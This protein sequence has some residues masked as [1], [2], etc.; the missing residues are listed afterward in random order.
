MHQPTRVSFSSFP[1]SS[2]AS[3]PYLST[4]LF[5]LMMASLLAATSTAADRP[6]IPELLPLETVAC[7]RVADS[8]NLVERFQETALGRM[9]KDPQI[10]PLLTQLFGSATDAF[11]QIEERLGLSLD[12]LLKL[13][14]GEIAL[15]VVPMEQRRPALL[16][17]MDTGDGTESVDKLIKQARKTAAERGAR[18][19]TE[20]VDGTELI[21]FHRA[22]DDGRHVAFFH[23]QETAVI[24]SD[25]ELS[26]TLLA[27]WSGKGEGTL[28]GNAK[29]SSIMQRCGAHRKDGPQISWYVDPIE[30]AK[31]STRGDL[32]AAAGLAFLPVMGLDGLSGVGGT[33]SIATE[34]FDVLTETH[35]LLDNPR[36]GV[37]DMIAIESGETQPES[38][39][40]GEVTRYMTLNWD[41]RKTYDGG[42]K[43]YDSFRGENALAAM[44]KQ[45]ATDQLGVDFQTELLAACDGRVSFTSWIELPVGPGAEVTVVGIKL[46]DA[47]KFAETLDKIVGKF[48]DNLSEE[49]YS[50]VV[51]HKFKRRERDADV[52][53]AAGATDAEPEDPQRAARRARRRAARER[54]I[55]CM[56]IVGDYLV[57]TNRPT[58][59]EKVIATSRDADLSLAEQLDYKLIA[60]KVRDHIG[61]KQPGMITFNRPEL[62]L[63][64]L[65]DLATNEDNRK[66]L[67]ERAE[68]GKFAK[69]FHDALEANPLPPFKVIS[70]YLAPAGGV[71]T[72]EENGIHYTGF[73]LRRADRPD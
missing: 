26:R 33:I 66:Q 8:R 12:Q 24:T 5:S 61:A 54:Q 17:L 68:N 9:S 63:R 70:K 47:D 57:M 21:T 37:L 7:V 48:A 55:P 28:A 53:P 43:L 13:P 27:R 65:Y 38:W 29:F 44:L 40:P 20:K 25:V 19:T 18:E 41:L 64:A 71:L 15:A 73:T 46:A 1:V 2:L 62:L 32:S 42:A 3:L 14:Q 51:Y 72:N 34:T 16:V 31:A 30:L 39:V 4:L 35:V 67:A 50:G 69:V 23:K 45:R 36:A 6:A 10:R 11:A 52:D 59:M 49:N 22:Q 58:A 56:G 60:S